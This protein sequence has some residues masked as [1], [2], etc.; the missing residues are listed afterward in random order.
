MGWEMK[1]KIKTRTLGKNHMRFFF[2]LKK[3]FQQR[4]LFKEKKKM[5]ISNR[6]HF[7]VNIDRNKS[8]RNDREIFMPTTRREEEKYILR[9]PISFE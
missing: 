1:K 9:I 7:S 6:E 8:T 4:L 2:S 5:I 3:G